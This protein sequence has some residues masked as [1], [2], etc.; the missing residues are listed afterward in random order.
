M[1]VSLTDIHPDISTRGRRHS[2]AK[3]MM[4]VDYTLWMTLVKIIPII[5]YVNKRKCC[6]KNP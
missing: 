3:A 6:R 5:P 2:E 1:Y 4:W